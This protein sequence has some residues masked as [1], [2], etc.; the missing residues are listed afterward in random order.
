MDKD[1][2]CVVVEVICLFSKF[3]GTTAP[4]TAPAEELGGGSNASGTETVGSCGL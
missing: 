4:E 3:N 1:G 2:T